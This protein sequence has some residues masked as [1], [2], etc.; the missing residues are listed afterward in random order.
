MLHEK[1]LLLSMPANFRNKRSLLKICDGW[2]WFLVFLG[3]VL[4]KPFPQNSG[5]R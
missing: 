5:H 1:L 3:S 2:F 4:K